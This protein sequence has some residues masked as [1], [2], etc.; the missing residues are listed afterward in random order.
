MINLL[1]GG[2][3]KKF[4]T[5]GFDIRAKYLAEVTNVANLGVVMEFCKENSLKWLVV[6]E[7]SNMLF[8]EDFDGVVI[9]MA[10]RKIEILAEVDG[11]VTLRAEAG[12]VWDDFV[13]Y[14]VKNGLYGVE[15][16]SGIP[17]TVGAS[18]VQNIGAYGAEAKDVIRGVEYFSIDDGCLKFI[19]VEDCRFTYRNSIFKQEL[20]GRVVVTAVLFKMSRRGMLNLSYGNL[21]EKLRQ[22]GESPT[23]EVVRNAVIEIRR[24]KLPEPSEIGSAGSFFQNPIVPIEVAERIRGNYPEVTLY[25]VDA[26]R[27]KVPAGWLI[28]KSGWKGFRR[29]DAGVYPHQALVL[30]NYGGATGA[31]VLALAR[32]IRD[33]VKSKFGIEL[34][35]EVNVI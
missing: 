27:V 23:L 9:T 6:G 35:F 15:N 14:C 28:D 31:E 19:D 24:A 21:E 5:F 3:L 20:A 30:V 12:V 11:W 8:T 17:G 10:N 26:V 32:E 29:G 16:L 2:S 34:S 25:P 33:D 4:N 7:G 22:S 13:D 1:A 18:P